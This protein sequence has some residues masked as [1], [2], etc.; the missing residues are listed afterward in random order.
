MILP[1]LS[2]NMTFKALLRDDP[3]GIHYFIFDQRVK[4]AIPPGGPTT[5]RSIR[6]YC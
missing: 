3:E 5:K 2:Y 4:D 6:P 1:P